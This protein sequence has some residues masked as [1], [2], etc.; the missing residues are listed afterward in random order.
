MDLYLLGHLAMVV[1][2]LVSIAACFLVWFDG[3]KADHQREA[4]NSARAALEAATR[5]VTQRPR[6]RAVS[7]PLPNLK[8]TST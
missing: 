1:A 3:L 7:S 2:L 6:V 4:K 8:G 5:E